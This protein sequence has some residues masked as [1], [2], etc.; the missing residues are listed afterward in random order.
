MGPNGQAYP[1][2]SNELVEMVNSRTFEPDPFKIKNS[3][4][5]NQKKKKEDK[6]KETVRAIIKPIPNK[7]TAA[8]LD[9]A[10]E[11]VPDSDNEELESD[12][13]ESIN[14]NLDT[15]RGGEIK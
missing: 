3:R 7:P 1:N 14:G 4:R 11:E 2:K 12:N 15:S 13:E 6:D 8:K 9:A 10:K 5:G